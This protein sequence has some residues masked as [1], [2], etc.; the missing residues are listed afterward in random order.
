[1][2]LALTY[3]PRLR[4]ARGQRVRTT[5][6]KLLARLSVARVVADKHDAPGFSLA[7]YTG[8]RRALANVERVFAVGLDLDHLDA[9][10]VFDRRE[11]GKRGEATDWPTLT[12]RFDAV[13]SFLHTT[14]SST[15]DAPRARVFIR[16]SRPVTGDEYRRVYAAC[17]GV[18]EER[19]LV[20]DRQA[21]DPSRFWFLPAIP[22]GGEYR[23]SIGRGAPVNVDWALA[24][25]PAPAPPAPPP[26]HSRPHVANTNGLSDEERAERYLDRC[27]PAVSGSGGHNTTFLV[28]QKLVRGFALDEETA[29][30]LL[31]RWNE[32]CSP[33]W[34]E[35]ELRRKLRQAAERGRMPE[36]ALRDAQR[37]AS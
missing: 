28:A 29:Y 13:D 2:S 35:R 37:R 23:Y 16:L 14:W 15:S 10:S 31:A 11:A 3:F 19:G 8:E 9:V 26:P 32:R 34:S 27:E 24:T 4:S 5:W 22:P 25:V 30:R 6:D 21:S 17:A 33:P 1:M 20:V 36:G 7:T 12:E 18:A